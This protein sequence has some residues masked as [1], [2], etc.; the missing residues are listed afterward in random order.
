MKHL[1]KEQIVGFLVDAEGCD[2]SS[3][4]HIAACPECS[5]AADVLR[6]GLTNFR[7]SLH[8]T[9]EQ[10]EPAWTGPQIRALAAQRSLSD[11]KY[12]LLKWAAMPALAAVL[13]T[14]FL[15]R[16]E[17]PPV[18]NVSNDASDEALLMQVNTAVYREA[19]MALA[20]AGLIKK[21]RTKQ[22]TATGKKK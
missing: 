7:D 9:A 2:P 10:H 15:V 13:L 21:E 3:R 6:S 1:E 18:A 17:R 11:R 5:A 12:V 20:P 8:Q 4:E 16:P 14:A 22:L 19:P